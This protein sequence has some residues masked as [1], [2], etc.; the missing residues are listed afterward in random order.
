MSKVCN[1]IFISCFVNLLIRVIVWGSVSGLS[2]F[3]I[4]IKNN[5]KLNKKFLKIIKYLV[6]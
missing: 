6:Y 1:F 3:I 5:V 4:F 2:K